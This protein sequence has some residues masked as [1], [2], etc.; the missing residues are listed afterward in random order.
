[1]KI[2]IN[3]IH[4]NL[5]FSAAHMIPEHDSCG[6]IHGHSYHVDVHLE[7]KRSG[8][9]GFVVDF[10]ELK[11]QVK[12][13][14]SQLDHKFLIPLENDSILFKSLEDSVEFNIGDKE[15]KLPIQDCILL[16]IPSTSAE[17][18]SIYFVDI[19]W[20]K[21]KEKGA[22][23]SV[24]QICINEGIGQGACYTLSHD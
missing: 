12:E 5:R 24:I 4:A 2:V 20:D 10:K 23:I 7:G 15:Y 22:D 6:C 1:M 9:F 17:D 3:G 21:L 16:P 11:S 14:C 8:K 18:L 19:L 13:I